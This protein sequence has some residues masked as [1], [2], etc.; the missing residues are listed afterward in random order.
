MYKA[1]KHTRLAIVI[2]SVLIIGGC[3]VRTPFSTGVDQTA[4]ENAYK[5]ESTVGDHSIADGEMVKEFPS[6]ADF[7]RDGVRETAR[8]TASDEGRLFKLQIFD[9]QEEILWEAEAATAHPGWVSFF[10][11]KANGEDYLLKYV[12]YMNQGM[13]SYQ[14]ELFFL[15]SS[16]S[17]IIVDSDS[18]DFD[19]NIGSP[20][21]LSFNPD[22]I[23]EFMNNVNAYLEGSIV[24]LNTDGSLEFEDESNLKDTLWWLDA[25]EGF[26]YDET[27]DLKDILKAYK[28]Y[29]ES[30]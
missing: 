2:L 11:Y 20:V 6:I 9:F 4:A 19:I 21:H 29:C 16:G 25:E 22:E 18:V 1:K 3:S 12:P 23:A 26:I 28:E 27:D 24:L 7:D 13:C 14:Y 5:G 17:E 30:R 15:D 10:L 8:V